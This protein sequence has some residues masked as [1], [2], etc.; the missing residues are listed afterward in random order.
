MRDETLLTTLGREPAAHHGLVNMPVFRGSTVLSP[1][2]EAYAGRRTHE[3]T[4]YGVHGTPTTFAFEEAM[5]TLENGYRTIAV[6]S[7]LAAITLPLAALLSAGDHLLVVDSAYQPTRRFCDTTLARFGVEVQYYDPLIGAGIEALIKDNTRLVLL[8]SPGSLTFEIQDVPAITA[9]TRRR[10]VLTL[11]DNT[12]ATPL[13]FKPLDHGVDISIHAI[14]KYVG[15]HS[16]ILMGSVTTTEAVHRPLRDAMG[17]FGDCVSPEICFLALRGLRSLA[18]RLER[19][20]K[21]A[22]EVARWLQ[23]RPEVARVLYPALEDDPGHGLWKR[24]MT[25]ATSLFGV[26]LEPTSRPALAAMVDPLD[27][28]GIGASWGGFESLITAPEPDRIRTATR[29]QAEGPLL[30]LHIG[31]EEPADLIEDLTRGF[32][33]RARHS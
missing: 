5:T 2:L 10:G 8:E 24:D 17:H 25:G 21:S 7:G 32:E 22:L 14:T 31:L 6:S 23:S 18:A 27:L 13:F 28:F 9:V 20:Q 4:T 19:Q 11:I 26:V 1:T 3:G 12:W 29:W 30:R 16:D 33:R 15:G